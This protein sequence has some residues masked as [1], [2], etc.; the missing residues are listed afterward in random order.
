MTDSLRSEMDELKR[1][2][3]WRECVTLDSAPGPH[4]IIEGKPYLHLCSNNYLDLA[5]HPQV[6]EAAIRATRDW[7]AGSGAARLVTGTSRLAVELE[8][9]LAAFKRAE[10]ALLFSSGYLANLGAI[11]TL[12]GQ[13]DWLICDQLNH[14]SL[15]DACRLSGADIK[16]YPHN[17]AETVRA[18]LAKAPAHARKLIITDGVFSMDGDLAPLGELNRLALEFGAWLIVDDAHGTGVVG[19]GGRGSCAQFGVA[20]D[21][22][23]QIMTLSKAMGSQGGAVIAAREVIELMVNR[24][25]AFIFETALV[26]AALGAAK[27]SLRIIAAEPERLEKVKISARM[28]RAGFAK[29]GFILSDGVIPILPLVYGDAD[30]TLR[31]SEALRERGYWVTAIRP[32]S[33][34]AGKSRLRLTVTSGHE[35]A[36]LE[37]LIRDAENFLP[38]RKTRS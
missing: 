34:E 20:G 15:I 26:P 30:K 33:V 5:T 9:Q 35:S 24:A 12:A 18:I 16:I 32:P 28:V 23:V 21:H 17:D 10:A 37:A 1:Q 38:S 31:A 13:G 3:L 29:L 6:I 2:G 36:E 4:I 7:G 22:V 19:E 8:E 27:E 25:R 11:T 14:A